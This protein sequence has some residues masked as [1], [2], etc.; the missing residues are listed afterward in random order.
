[1]GDLDVLGFDHLV[2]RCTDIERTL[3][4]YVEDL[5]LEPVRVDEWRRGEVFF[6]SVRVDPATII[7]LVPQPDGGARRNVDHLCLVASAETI[8]RIDAARD[9][10][11]VVDGPD[12][13]Y[14]ARGNGWSIY[15]LDPDD[16]MVELRSYDHPAL[17]AR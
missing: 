11:R 13:R 14:G 4:W 6:P 5:G 7:D 1:M 10:Y 9:R 12:L 3:A 16:T 17:G 8:D 2:L 15:V